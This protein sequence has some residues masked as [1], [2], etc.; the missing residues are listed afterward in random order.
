MHRSLA[1]LTIWGLHSI[2]IQNLCNYYFVK[3]YDKDGAP[4]FQAPETGDRGWKSSMHCQ[5]AH[6]TFERP[7]K[8]DVFRTLQRPLS[9]SGD[10]SIRVEPC[11]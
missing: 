8:R 10:A 3:C 11:N 9:G 6:S 2:I 5:C 7:A 1:V 4:V